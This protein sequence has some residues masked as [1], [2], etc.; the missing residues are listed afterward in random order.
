MTSDGLPGRSTDLRSNSDVRAHSVERRERV[1]VPDPLQECFCREELTLMTD[2]K[3][4]QFSHH[5]AHVNRFFIPGRC[6]CRRIPCYV[7]DRQERLYTYRGA[8]EQGSESR[9][10][11]FI[12]EWL[13]HV[14]VGAGI[15][16]CF[17]VIV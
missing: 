9:C 17:G 2:K 10:Q 13:L 3:I 5:W 12:L 4:E 14:V 15:E 8:P 7:T 1:I 16:T 11:Y 6:A